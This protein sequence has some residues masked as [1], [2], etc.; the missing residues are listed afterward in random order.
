LPKIVTQFESSVDENHL[1]YTQALRNTLQKILPHQLWEG[2]SEHYLEN[3]HGLLPFVF[4]PTVN[5]VP[6]NLSFYAIFKYRANAFQFFFEMISHWLIP[7]KRLNA[8]WVHAVDFWIPEISEERYTLCEV[9]VHVDNH[10]DLAEVQRNLPRIEREA[11]L[12]L[13][14]SYHA[15]RILGLKGLSLDEKTALVQD[16]IAYLIQRRPR[17][18][19]QDVMTE[20]QHAFAMCSDT[21]KVQRDSR[22]LSRVISVHYLF[23]KAVRNAIRLLPEKRYLSLK[24]F[25]AH[26]HLPKGEKAVLAILVGVNFLKDKEAF[27]KRHILGAIQNYISNAQVVEDSFFTN[28]RGTENICTLYLEIEKS[29]GEF[30]TSA[31][32]KTLR[33]ELPIDLKDRIEQLMHPVFMPRNEEEIMRNVLIL[34]NQI[35]FI[36]DI[37]QVI[38]NFDEQTHTSLFFTI[39][40]VR[41]LKPQARSIQDLFSY[42][43]TFLSY[44]HDR[45]KAVGTLRKKHVKEATIFRVKISKEQFLRRDHSIDLYKARQTV[46]MEL[47]RVVGEVRDY[48]GGMI[49][50]QNELLATL[51]DLMGESIKYREF[52]LENFFYSI[53]PV[54]MRAILN[55]ECLKILFEIQL[56]IIDTPFSNGEG[57]TLKMRIEND[58]VYVMIKA[59]ERS[60]KDELTQ[61]FTKQQI[62]PFDLANSYV[63]IYDVPYVGFLYRCS[64]HEKQRHFCQTV[65]NVINTWE[66]KRRAD[67][68]L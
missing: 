6:V 48:N 52:L 11:K 16:H 26:I 14:S 61:T 3:L 42:K 12:G 8:V 62:P 50:K 22:H 5:D 13:S 43:E 68:L 34:S 30:F 57:Y 7:P 18:F 9:M 31:E 29:N 64:D 51:R 60:I 58:F 4:N 44:I 10:M 56:E 45:C 17:D 39:I 32:I 59:Q 66:Y 65:H 24:I 23:R 2:P 54:T 55:P 20:M 35:K 28:R 25:R 47:C 41:V 1:L 37:P 53:M 21:F 40:L 67:A 27:E 15:R 19:D 33:K 38:I 36:R 63:K 49:S 46:C